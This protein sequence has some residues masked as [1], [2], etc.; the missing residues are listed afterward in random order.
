MWSAG[1]L[2]PFP[3]HRTSQP[4]HARHFSTRGHV[5]RPSRLRATPWD[6]HPWRASR[7]EP[8]GGRSGT[9]LPLGSAR[10]RQRGEVGADPAERTRGGQVV[11]AAGTEGRNCELAGPVPGS[12]GSKIIS[13][14]TICSARCRASPSRLAL[15]RY[16]SPGGSS[17]RQLPGQRGD[18]LLDLFAQAGD[19]RLQVLDRR[20]PFR[21]PPRPV[22]AGHL[23]IL[24]HRR[25]LPAV[26]R[27]RRHVLHQAGRDWP[28]PLP[29]RTGPP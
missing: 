6:P 22:P 9:A 14:R 8:L 19:E 7:R 23:A 20:E 28:V 4:V 3:R 27:T 13:S 16:P 18:L 2:L 15:S 11:L 21:Q 17:P 24:V 29:D 25:R 1:R 5:T 10:G 26:R 12:G